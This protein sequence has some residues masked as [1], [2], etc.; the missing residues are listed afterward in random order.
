MPEY[1]GISCITIVEFFV[2]MSRNPSSVFQQLNIATQTEN[3]I[4]FAG[5]YDV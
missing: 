5:N 3:V 2:E 4:V 1:A